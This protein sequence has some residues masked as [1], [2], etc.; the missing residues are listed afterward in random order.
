MQAPSVQLSFVY[1]FLIAEFDAISFGTTSQSC[2]FY[3]TCNSYHLSFFAVSFILCVLNKE[4]SLIVKCLSLNPRLSSSMPFRYLM[5][6]SSPSSAQK[7][8][9]KWDIITDVGA[10]T[11]CLEFSVGVEVLL[12]L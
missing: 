12:D 2:L 11:K 6:Y 1:F 3:N 5:I 7:E 10:L 9:Y 4:H 8:P